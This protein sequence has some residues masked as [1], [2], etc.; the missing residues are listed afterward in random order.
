[1]MLISIANPYLL[2]QLSHM[3][4]TCYMLQSNINPDAISGFKYGYSFN[5]SDK[6]MKLRFIHATAERIVKALPN[7]VKGVK[8]VVN[9]S[10][11]HVV[12][13]YIGYSRDTAW[14]AIQRAIDKGKNP[15]CPTCKMPTPEGV[16]CFD[17]HCNEMAAEDGADYWAQIKEDERE[18]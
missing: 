14:P 6:V 15:V 7:Y 4:C 18:L 16:T 17:C 8:V 9:P 12:L 11:T 13:F 2:L 3:R 1:M 10:N 5:G